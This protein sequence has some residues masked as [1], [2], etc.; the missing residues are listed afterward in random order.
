MSAPHLA[1][2]NIALLKAPLDDPSMADFAAALDP[3]NALADASP[4]FVWRYTDEGAN[5]ASA[6]RPF[7]PDLLVNLSVWEDVESLRSYTYGNSGHLDYL[8]RRRE[9]FAP[10]GRPGLVLWWVPAGTLPT[11][12]E[13]GERLE[14][15]TANGPGPKAFTFRSPFPAPGAGAGLEHAS[16]P[17]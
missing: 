8:R 16:D 17:G 15:L 10:L 1:Q 5:D 6:S 12:S 2:L 3:I 9:W 11:L 13:A 4:G 14:R 7:G